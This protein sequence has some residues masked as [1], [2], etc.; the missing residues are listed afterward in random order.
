MTVGTRVKRVSMSGLALYGK[1]GTVV[2]S[3]ANRCKVLFDQ[4]KGK[5]SDDL[6]LA[7]W[8]YLDELELI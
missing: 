4:D 8:F 7:H 1:C 5:C 6:V 2:A 3:I